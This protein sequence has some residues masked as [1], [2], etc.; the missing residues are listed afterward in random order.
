MVTPQLPHLMTEG[1][2]GLYGLE[3]VELGDGLVRARVQV[4]DEVK[5]PAG[6]VHGGVYSSIAESIASMATYLAVAPEGRTAMGLSN[7]TSFLRPILEGHVHAEARCRHRGRTTW[8]WEVDFTDDDGHL[9]ALTRMTIAV[10][11][12]RA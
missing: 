2:D 11:E 4:R 3:L 10:R 6:L 1:F 12:P 9:C 7:Q 8:V 5:Q